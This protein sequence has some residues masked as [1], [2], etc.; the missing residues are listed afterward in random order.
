MN[1]NKDGNKIK[2]AIAQL[3]KTGKVQKAPKAPKAEKAPRVKKVKEPKPI[4]GTI[5]YTIQ[6]H[7]DI[8]DINKRGTWIGVIVDKDTK[9]ETP[10]NT[11]KEMRR[12]LKSVSKETQLTK[13]N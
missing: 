8:V 10:F 12:L 2:A 6:I 11:R 7:S 1:E 13:G 9:I 5:D 3:G 4:I